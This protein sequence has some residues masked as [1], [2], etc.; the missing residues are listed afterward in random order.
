MIDGPYTSL[1]G[2]KDIPTGGTS[3]VHPRGRNRERREAD[4]KKKQRARVKIAKASKRRNR[5]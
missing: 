5:K 4:H 3:K 1:A 2:L